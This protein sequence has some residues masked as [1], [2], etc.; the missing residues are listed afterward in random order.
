M[1]KENAYEFRKKMLC[2]HKSSVRDMSKKPDNDMLDLQSG[3]SVVTDVSASEVIRTAALDFIN[4]LDISMG[5]K[6]SLSY[7][8]SHSGKGSITVHLAKDCGVELGDAAGYKGYKIITDNKN[9]EIYAYDDRGAA[10]ALYFLEDTMQLERAPYIKRG[11]VQSRAMFSPQMVHSGYAFDEYPDEYLSQIAH[12]GRDAILVYTMDVNRTPRGYV[13]FNGLIDR[14]ARYGIDVYAYSYL[15]SDMNPEDEGAEEYYENNYG[16]LFR[17]CPRLKGVTLVGEAVEFP[18]RDPHVAQG[19]YY[20]TTTDGII[21]GK[22]S[23]GMY[24][25]EDYPVWLNLLKRII[26]KY[27]ENADIVFWSYN[28][29]SQPEEAR[30]KLI[31]S[32]PSDI[33]LQATFEMYEPRHFG[34]AVSHCA[35]Y[36]LSFEG[37]GKY[38]ISEAEAAKK[39]GIRLYSMTN[40]AGMTWDFG[41][42]PYLPMP[43]QWI[44][45]LEAV[46]NAKDRWGL[47]GL[48]ECHH[49]GYYPSF[50]SKLA[51]WAFIEPRV[52]LEDILEKLIKSEFG[53]ENYAITNQAL[54]LWSDA[55]RHYTPSDADQYGPFRVGPSYPFCLYRKTTLP[56]SKDTS[57]MPDPMF[58]SS[59]CVPEYGLGPD[60]RDSITGIRIP[61]EIKSLEKA[62]RLMQQ[63]IDLLSGIK[64]PNNELL[65]LLNMGKFIR[66]S[67]TTGIDAKRWFLLKNRLFIADTKEEAAELLDKMESLLKTEIENAQSTIPIVEA[68][69]RL[70]WEP[71]MLYVTDRWHL[72]WKIRQVNAVIDYE[73]E[74]YRKSLEL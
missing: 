4:F 15:A 14:A 52:L 21:H 67:I 64:T 57:S 6:A 61:E 37:P 36:T 9:I 26:R 27:N 3:I 62:Y 56:S 23:S 31:E 59:I 74:E 35:D 55:I 5:V 17:E 71:R 2:I 29:G 68:D 73:I 47:C 20:E 33:S 51:K 58:G 12:D 18:S 10:Q 69:S 50:I 72:E 1:K 48:M 34:S 30:V 45:R 40:T 54:E 53:E 19:R 13:D 24:P 49:Y 66:N 60:K 43:H 22:P 38:F 16:R 25:C 41:P 28:W 32:L 11:E 46:R 44:R 65:T 42:I 70:G 7:G 39:R 63:G 8:G